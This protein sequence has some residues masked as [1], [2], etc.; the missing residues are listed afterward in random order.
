MKEIN[1]RKKLEHLF[2]VSFM[3]CLQGPICNNPDV[4]DLYCQ[5]VQDVDTH[6]DIVFDIISQDFQ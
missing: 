1:L 4:Q 3:T 5:M 6:V 2:G